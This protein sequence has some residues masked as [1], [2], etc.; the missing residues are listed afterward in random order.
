[1][2]RRNR[3]PKH[4]LPDFLDHSI[5][6]TYI[7]GFDVHACVSGISD[8]NLAEV[9]AAPFRIFETLRADY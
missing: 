2:D 4:T 6:L 5:F 1:M 8:P 3:G 9:G 7:P